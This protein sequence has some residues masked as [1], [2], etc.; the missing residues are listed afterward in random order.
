MAKKATKKVV[1]QVKKIKEEV[2]TI[3]EV[4]EDF[5]SED[6]EVLIPD[7]EE[8]SIP[9]EKLEKEI[10]HVAEEMTVIWHVRNKVYQKSSFIKTKTL[11][12]HPTL[13]QLPDDI[14]RYLTNKWWWSNVYLKWEEWLLKHKADMNMIEKLKKF[15]S[16]HYL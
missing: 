4:E 15:L 5:I 12:T 11:K 6:A 8:A 10:K 9:E 7:V 14:R 16:D 13:N 3:P 2:K 1:K